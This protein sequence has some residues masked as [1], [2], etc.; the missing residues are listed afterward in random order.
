MDH[1]FRLA[2]LEV[3]LSLPPP[4]RDT[5]LLC[6]RDYFFVYFFPPLPSEMYTKHGWGKK[7]S[8]HRW[9]LSVSAR[10]AAAHVAATVFPLRYHGHYFKNERRKNK[11]T[12][13]NINV[14]MFS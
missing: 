14:Q 3:D 6:F 12:N 13:E 9:G 1:A 10:N 4:S 7:T 8:C 2:L 11:K 5:R